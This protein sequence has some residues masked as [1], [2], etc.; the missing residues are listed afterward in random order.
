LHLLFR[1]VDVAFAASRSEAALLTMLVAGHTRVLPIMKFS[2]PMRRK[3][4]KFNF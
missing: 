1:S 3:K 4:L 2:N